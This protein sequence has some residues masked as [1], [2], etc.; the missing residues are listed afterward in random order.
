MIDENKRFILFA[1]FLFLFCLS[2]VA[3]SLIYNWWFLPKENIGISGDVEFYVVNFDFILKYFSLKIGFICT[4]VNVVIFV[5]CV[6]I[7]FLNKYYDNKEMEKH[8]KDLKNSND[9]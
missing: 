5:V 6:L 7:Y 3:N 2:V 4:F 9:L 1:I 8:I